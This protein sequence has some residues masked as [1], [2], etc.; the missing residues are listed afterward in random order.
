MYGTSFRWLKPTKV[1]SHLTF[2]PTEATIREWLVVWHV[3]V[4]LVA[5]VVATAWAVDFA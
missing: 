5:H 4:P 1:L 2:G 3:D